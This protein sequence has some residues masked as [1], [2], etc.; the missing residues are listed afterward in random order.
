MSGL[1]SAQASIPDDRVS[2]P[3]SGSPAT[4]G[5]AYWHQLSLSGGFVAAAAAITALSSASPIRAPSL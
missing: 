1:A 5:V 2:E 3:G 4:M